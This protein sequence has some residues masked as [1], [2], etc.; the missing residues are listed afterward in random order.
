M[1]VV[2]IK[3]DLDGEVGEIK[4]WIRE[5]RKEN[6]QIGFTLISVLRMKRKHF[7]LTVFY[8]TG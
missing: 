2:S 1:K 6:S 4:K 5:E 3:A 7:Y 8:L